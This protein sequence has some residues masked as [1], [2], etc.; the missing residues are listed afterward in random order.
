MFLALNDTGS[1]QELA[2]IAEALLG[3]LKKVARGSSQL[4]QA[5]RY[6][7]E[8]LKDPHS[9][10]PDKEL[11]NRTYLVIRCS[12]DALKKLKS[13]SG[14]TSEILVCNLIRRYKPVAPGGFRRVGRVEGTSSEPSESIRVVPNRIHY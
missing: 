2:E 14:L 3:L 13:A 10:K 5:E 4:A 9:T 6:H 7:E 12:V 11:A 1:D 8:G